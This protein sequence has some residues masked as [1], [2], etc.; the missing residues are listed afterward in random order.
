[1]IDSRGTSLP[2]PL[3][4]GADFERDLAAVL[5]SGIHRALAQ[6]NARTRFRFTAI[7]RLEQRLLR[8][9][10]L[11]DRENPTINFAGPVVAPE[12]CYREA[13]ILLGRERVGTDRARQ[14]RPSRGA[15]AASAEPVSPASHVDVPLRLPSGRIAGVLSHIDPRPRLLPRSEREKL[16]AVASALAIRLTELHPAGRD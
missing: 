8:S 9:V 3:P 1:M 13:G 12:S 6:L 2:R 5:S 15:R 11:Y 10:C 16:D 7:Y 14:L 4:D